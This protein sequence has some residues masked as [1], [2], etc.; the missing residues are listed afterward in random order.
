M[1]YGN[2]SNGSVILTTDPST[3]RPITENPEPSSI[4][5]GFHTSMRFVDSGNSI[6]QVWDIVPDAGTAQDAA[7]QLAQMQA[8]KLSDNDALLVPALFP[9][10]TGN[11]VVYNVGDRVLYNG[12]LYKVLQAHTSQADWTP[13]AASSLFAKVLAGQAGTTIGEWTQPDSTNP[14]SKGD[15]VTH[16]GKTWQSMVD[17]NVWEPGASGTESLW[18]EVK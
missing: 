15:K 4:P 17:N 18:S 6:A 8:S 14:Y 2:F 12:V 16:K 1:F 5:A 9:E 13:D 3:G 7:I 11:A 10:W